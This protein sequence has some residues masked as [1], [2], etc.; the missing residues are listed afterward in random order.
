[1][2]TVGFAVDNTFFVGA[3]QRYLLLVNGMPEKVE[4]GV[5]IP[6]AG[7]AD[8]NDFFKKRPEPL[9]GRAG[10]FRIALEPYETC[11]YTDVP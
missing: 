5:S 3:R 9:T 10:R 1:M 8:W 7:S 11:V 6:D 4:T 2:A